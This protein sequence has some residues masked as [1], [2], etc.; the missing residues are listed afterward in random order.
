[1]SIAIKVAINIGVILGVAVSLN[2]VGGIL[3]MLLLM[4]P[5]SAVVHVSSTTEFDDYEAVK[6]KSNPLYLKGCYR[7]Y[8]TEKKSLIKWS[9]FKLIYAWQIYV[10]V[11]D[12]IFLVSGI[13]TDITCE[14]YT[15]QW[16]MFPAA[17][18][19]I[20][21]RHAIQYHYEKILEKGLKKAERKMVWYPF[22]IEYAN[23]NDVATPITLYTKY[24]DLTELE[25]RLTYVCGQRK[26][27]LWG[28]LQRSSLGEVS[29]YLKDDE[30]LTKVFIVVDTQ[31][32]DE[33]SE[34]EQSY[35]EGLKW[36]IDSVLEDFFTKYFGTLEPKKDICLTILTCTE[37]LENCL[38][39][40]NGA[41]HQK[42][43]R[44]WLPAVLSFDT[45][46]MLLA[47]QNKKYG[48][49]QYERLKAE[50]LDMLNIK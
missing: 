48:M 46:V 32:K 40:V 8:N 45:G 29:L 17:F 10:I 2:R 30:H 7:V 5:V 42:P 41:V 18:L 25:R 20:F 24:F 33:L 13:S 26:F 3:C 38:Y 12:I 16:V 23:R 21:I 27:L 44:Y 50:L 34:L 4:L 11:Q 43:G 15:I 35:R 28:K 22:N 39:I 37:S 9:D 36:Q 14:W 47:K 1:M 31:K 19:P 49:D 6:N